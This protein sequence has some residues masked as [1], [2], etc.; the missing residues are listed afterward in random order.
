[1]SS[2]PKQFDSEA[3]NSLRVDAQPMYPWTGPKF[4]SEA[5]NAGGRIDLEKTLSKGVS[6]DASGLPTET[7]SF[8]DNEEMKE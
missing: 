5:H 4:V 6:G 3:A 7:G 1:M 2:L 8:N